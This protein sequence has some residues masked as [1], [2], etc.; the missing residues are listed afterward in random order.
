MAK[1]ASVITLLCLWISANSQIEGVVKDKN[2][3]EVL[4]GATVII[5]GVGTVTS[6]DGMFTCDIADSDTLV[7]LTVTFVGYRTYNTQVVLDSSYKF[8]TVAL[9]LA[10]NM[11]DITT[12]TA[13][14]YDKPLAESTV[15]LDV[16]S[17][18]LVESMNAT[19]LDETLEKIPGVQI[20]GGQAN[21]RGGSG[22]SYGAGSR[23]MLLVD[24]MPILTADASF[25]NWD[26]LPL[27][28]VQQIEVLKGA[29]SALYGS[30]AL[31]GIINVRTTYPTEV[32]KTKVS[33]FV[34]WLLP[35]KDKSKQWWDT[36]P[37]TQGVQAMHSR[38]IKKLDLVLG[39]Y[40]FNRN[41][42]YQE[43]DLSYGRFNFN[44]LYR[45][46]DRLTL[47]LN[48]NFNRG[49]GVNYF[50]WQ[51]DRE[52]AY[53]GAEG[54]A[55]DSDRLRFN[56]D[57][58]LKYYSPKGW[59]HKLANRFYSIRNI[60]SDNRSN[61]TRN[62]YSEYQLAKQWET[63][64][65][66]VTGGLVSNQAGISA[67]LY[68]DTTFTFTNLA[69][70]L[71]LEKKFFD[72]LTINL[73]SRLEYFKLKTPNQVGGIVINQALNEEVKPVFRL[74][75]NYALT[76]QTFIRASWGQGF[77]F[78]TVAEKFI[79]TS[80]GP[81]LISPNPDLR[82]EFGWSTE[83]GIKQGLKIGGWKGFLDIAGFWSEYFDMMEFLFVSFS[84]GFQ[85]TNVGDT[86]ISGFEASIAGQSK[87][88]NVPINLIAGYTYINPE[89]QNFTEEDQL[90]S[91]VDYNI[92]KYRSK[93][94]FK[95][96]LEAQ[97]NNVAVGI[98]HNYVSHMEAVDAIFE[99]VIP[100]LQNFRS[101]NN[102][103]YHLLNLRT[104]VKVSKWTFSVL[105][106]NVLNQEYAVRPG[107]LEDPMSITLKAGIDF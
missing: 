58:I 72:K 96:D 54:T 89:F 77:R 61:T 104:S 43:S 42:A 1:M 59:Q 27:E 25:P 103:G 49:Q 46:N 95:I 94:N 55:N 40:L 13:S 85:S 23:V 14:K 32:P 65:L 26:D 18:R 63:T 70:Y 41:T 22:F 34:H 88:K 99:F 19:S 53:L 101:I 7:T 38:K 62:L 6:L 100:G 9:S 2:T 11:L 60:V 29:S 84:E 17:N 76:S 106:N 44:T 67:E 69:A 33:T 75:L 24:D 4:P 8:V 93:H 102:R 20:V 35:P 21:I 15:S 83:L 30:S 45:F 68:G 80:L 91:S 87:L 90:R 3:E 16:V 39:A 82:S 56:I 52:G 37:G 50:Y 10:D 71:Q 66:S 64:G 57:P 28:S 73:G 98:S 97:W 31:N 48:G 47:S 92:L 12:V 86:R 5:N 79:Q 36:P 105:A 51:D 74:G 107:L 78:P 81:T